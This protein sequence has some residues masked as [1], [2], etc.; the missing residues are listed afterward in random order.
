MA[1]IFTREEFYDLV[2]S[3]P[4]TRLAKEFAI[5]DVAL[6]KICKKHDIP[7]PPLG[8]WA[9]KA[10]GKSVTQTPLPK[11]KVAHLS[12]ISI[13]DGDL[14]REPTAIKRAREEARVLA[15]EGGNSQADL[16]HP[17]IERTIAW[18]TTAK[19]SERGVI[20]TEGVGLIRCEIGLASIDRVAIALPR[21][22]QAASLQGFQL[23][24][25]DGFAKFK[26]DTESVDFSITETV[27][28]QKHVLTASEVEEQEAWERK[29]DR[30]RRQNR[31]IDM[32]AEMPGLPDFDYTPTGQ[33][34]FEFEH[35]Y[36]SS[37]SSPRRSFKDAKVQRTEAM[38][39]DIAVGL[40]VF[41]AAK[42]AERLRR[43]KERQRIE[44]DR[45]RREL[46]A[47][48]KHIED[49]RVAGLGSILGELAEMDRLQRLV[50]M[51]SKEAGA[52]QGPRLS[53]FRAWS[54]DRLAKHEALLSA[55]GLESRFEDER[56]FGD[57][58][59]HDYTTSKSW[60]SSWR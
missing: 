52:T 6:H 15:S 27:K 59:D 20:A 13:A 45:I 60:Q 53:A 7:N 50:A 8:W 32:F 9:K 2:W 19:P 10:A 21:I 25:D 34:S 5:S 41:A 38:A 1:R 33:L 4:L 18:M 3:K 46:A 48:A 56:L 57:D 22:V 35:I 40:A 47:R 24:A 39:V 26:S 42:T 37:G 31:W 16:R 36:F 30:E 11:A 55:K 58:D 17:I 23:V 14:S 49:R 44:E 28:R 51:L 54:E 43:E 12:K 29:R